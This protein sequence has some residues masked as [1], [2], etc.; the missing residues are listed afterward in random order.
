MTIKYLD[1]TKEIRTIH[2]LLIYGA[3]ID[4]KDENGNT[5]T[6]Y[7]ESIEDEDLRE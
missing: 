7:V 5:P 2:K 3:F 1:E 6:D 4:S